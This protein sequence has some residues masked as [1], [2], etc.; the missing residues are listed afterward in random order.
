MTRLPFLLGTIAGYGSVACGTVASL[1]PIGLLL[2]ILFGLPAGNMAGVTVLLVQRTAVPFGLL[3]ALAAFFLAGWSH[4]TAK[5]GLTLTMVGVLLTVAMFGWSES[6]AAVLISSLAVVVGF[7][8]WLLWK[9]RA[10]Q[11][12]GEGRQ[13]RLTE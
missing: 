1:V 9:P 11:P 4:S 13:S 10:S 8:S 5:A 2:I 3:L 12:T 6:G 7:I